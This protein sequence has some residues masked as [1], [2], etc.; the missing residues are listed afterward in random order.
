MTV[1][2]VREPR[3]RTR[4]SSSFETRGRLLSLAIIAGGTVLGWAVPHLE[5]YLPSGG[6][7]YDASTAQAALGAIAAAM[8][9][10][11][12]FV[13][14]AVTLV[15]QTVQSMSPRLAGA[16]R[17][18]SRFLAIFALLVA[19]ALYALV[20]LS[21]IDPDATPRLAVTI[22]VALVLLDSVVVLNMLASL[23]KVVT[24]GGLSRSVGERLNS[25]I[26]AVY[27]SARGEA[28]TSTGLPDGA[29]KRSDV[30]YAGRPGTVRHL[31][32]RRLVRLAGSAGISI[33]M[34]VAVGDFVGARTRVARIVATHRQPPDPAL[35]ARIASCVS[36]GPTR[37][38]EQ[39][40]A[41]GI[42]LLADIAVR[43]LSPAVNDPTTAVQALDQIEESLLTLSA[44]ALGGF[45]LVDDEGVV[46]VQCPGPS[47]E[48]L[49]ALATDEIL[50]YGAANPQVARRTRALLLRVSAHADEDRRGPVHARLALLD[51]LIQRSAPD[52]YFRDLSLTPDPQGLG[53]PSHDDLPTTP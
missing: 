46:R 51:R 33:E 14:T 10:L 52:P 25:V 49:I 5:R 7:G 29:S 1:E 17:Y 37:T 15:I 43:A 21:Q 27:P 18:F 30:H 12:G 40:P 11:A 39:D 2:R 4:H 22:A 35:V 44:R 24:G 38:F 47:W 53:G 36:C 34:T 32:E 19:T 45:G 16:L 26:Q 8:I 41:Y 3:G 42:R 23:R 20:A 48:D 13:L 31:D 6:L 50:L 9:T 28:D